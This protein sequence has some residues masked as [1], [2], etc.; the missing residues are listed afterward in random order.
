ML[1]FLLHTEVVDVTEILVFYLFYL[2]TLLEHL[3]LEYF[4]ELDLPLLLLLSLLLL[5]LG[6][7]NLTQVSFLVFLQASH[8][9][10]GD[11]DMR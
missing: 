5:L 10:R 7:L 3:S 4:L 2:D 1:L 11:S 6:L 8:C 9:R